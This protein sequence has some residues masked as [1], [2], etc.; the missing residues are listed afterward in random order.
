M[1]AFMAFE[2]SNP[3][4]LSN[5]RHQNAVGIARN[6]DLGKCKD[7]CYQSISKRRLFFALAEDVPNRRSEADQL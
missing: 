7:L 5:Y 4:N 2:M 1:P 3:D 6:T